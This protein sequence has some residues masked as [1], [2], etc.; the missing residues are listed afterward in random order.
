MDWGFWLGTWVYLEVGG[1]CVV[2][3]GWGIFLNCI[4]MKKILTYPTK[5][6]VLDEIAF[7]VNAS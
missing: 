5:I 1:R 3:N 7:W 4:I 2:E 6:R